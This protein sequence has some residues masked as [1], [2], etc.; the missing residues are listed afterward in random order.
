[1]LGFAVV[2]EVWVK[3]GRGI[4]EA[5]S[6]LADGVS[7]FAGVIGGQPF[8]SDDLGRGLF[9][10]NT[11]SGAAGFAQRRD[12]LLKDLPAIVN[13]LQ[14]MAAGLVG[15]GD[16]YAAADQAIAQV[17][18]GRQAP[19]APSRLPGGGPGGVREYRLPPIPDGL[20][21]SAPPPN[22]VMQA[23]WLFERAGLT[24]AWPD[25]DSAAVERVGGAATKLGSA[26]DTVRGHVAD[27]ARRVTGSGSGEAT[28]AFGAIA[29]TVYA[30]DGL[31]A[32]LK[33]RCDDLAGY[34]RTAA[35][36]ILTAQWHFVASAVFAVGLM[37][38]VSMLG[39]FVEAGMA[40]ALSMI[41]LEGEALQIILNLLFEAVVGGVFS[42][43]SDVIEQLFRGGHFDWSELGG[44]LGQGL[45]LG[46]LM[47]GAKA[48]LPAVLRRGP[49]TIGLAKMMESA[50]AAGILSRF[51]VGW[52][53]GTGAIAATNKITGHGWDLEHAWQ[54]GLAMASIGAG[55]E[56]ITHLRKLI[57]PTDQSHSPAVGIPPFDDPF[58]RSGGIVDGEVMTVRDEIFPKPEHLL[59]RVL[60]EPAHAELGSADH[61]QS[62]QRA[63]EIHATAAHE[64]IDTIST[65]IESTAHTE[66]TVGP[67]DHPSPTALAGRAEARVANIE[68]IDGPGNNHVHEIINGAADYRAV[69]SLADPVTDRI[70]STGQGAHLPRSSADVSGD[71]MLADATTQPT[72]HHDSR[73]AIGSEPSSVDNG[74]K[75]I[76]GILN[77]KAADTPPK[78]DAPEII[79]PTAHGPTD[80]ATLTRQAKDTHATPQPTRRR[81][82]DGIEPAG[83]EDRAALSVGAENDTSRFADRPARDVDELIKRLNEFGPKLPGIE[84]STSFL[85]ELTG[86]VREEAYRRGTSPSAELQQFVVQR[87]MARSFTANPHD[88]KIKGGQGMLARF[89]DARVSGDVDFARIDKAARPEMEG[90]F[91]DALTLDLHDYLAF[92]PLGTADL[93]GGAGAR[94]AHRVTLGGRE[95]M[96]FEAD[97]LPNEGSPEW[98]APELIPF[99]RHI[100]ST[101]APGESPQLRVLSL[102]DQ[103]V[104]KVVAMYTQGLRTAESRC[105][106][107]FRR[108]ESIFACQEGDLPWRVKD[109][110]DT[111]F[112]ATKRSWDAEI[113]H[114]VLRA[115]VDFRITRGDPVTI[116]RRFRVP[117]PNW[118]EGFADYAGK[119]PGLAFKTLPEAKPLLKAFLAPL[120]SEHPLAGRW[121]PLR[122]EWIDLKRLSDEAERQRV[123]VVAHA[124]GRNQ[125]R[126]GGLAVAT[127]KLT[128]EM[129]GLHNTDVT[130]LTVGPA[131]PHGHA[132]VTS[133]PTHEAGRSRQAQLQDVARYGWPEQIEGLPVHGYDGFDWVI[134]HGKA[135]G[136]AAMLI[137]QRWYPY[138]NLMYVTHEPA[139]RYAEIQG[140]LERG[141]KRAAE[142]RELMQNADL[143]VGV[144][145]LNTDVARE[146]TAGSQSAPNHHELIPGIDTARE[147]V[148]SSTGETFNALFTTNRVSDPVKGYDDLLATVKELRDQGVPI[149]LRVRG[150]P[151]EN[152]ATEQQHADEVVGASG[153]VEILPHTTD[154]DE[155]SA[156]HDWAHVAVMPSRIEGFGMVGSEAA[157]RGVPVLVNAESGF[158]KFLEDASRVPPKLGQPSVTPDHGM[159]EDT[160]TR[161]EAWSRVVMR[162]AADYPARRMTAAKLRETLQGYSWRDA[163]EA[164]SKAMEGT[165]EEGYRYTVQGPHGEIRLHDTGPS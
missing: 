13:L 40:W 81:E 94:V 9:E 158:A 151:G 159:A 134:G 108:S 57:R 66:V 27:H 76:A 161:I 90:D 117:N 4:D 102:E 68:T 6:R 50:G 91:A 86:R 42:A 26:I 25:G 139:M 11:G 71:S 12:R 56:G 95:L 67:T 121:D 55:A 14:G 61:P 152:V 110:V 36:A 92:E 114:A 5:S 162:L 153:I 2:P 84:D 126:V 106:H 73:L 147:A 22:L 112:L 7:V 122:H 63:A 43:G 133:I 105:I 47:G 21:S 51:A 58:V 20:P 69:P 135:S 45:M 60:V 93:L 155:L 34:C 111:T 75:S 137:R 104:Q 136:S 123:L 99:P 154:T 8:G 1:M 72:G 109:L 142:E 32:D 115:E 49:A 85:K 83:N 62:A 156:D 65:S 10:G 79:P 38:A 74:G 15:A 146:M 59:E 132:R 16:R 19:T 131:E 148:A 18:S 101:G 54:T 17:L 78:V 157:G 41:R 100:F 24:V 29:R 77:V 163:A 33:Q 35:D 164:L 44:A 107:C 37:Y 52:G 140:V 116:P 129:A 89:P 124:S 46:G 127:G 138:A 143:V 165:E 30:Q 39:P 113:M 144:G 28:E 150:V 141:A 31:L 119:T 128:T 120:L 87:I 118:S 82:P 145:P 98:I 53:V 96:N 97:L 64:P 125:V 70:G 3:A 48:G 103:L 88:W 149:R 160:P 80:G 23:L 130:L